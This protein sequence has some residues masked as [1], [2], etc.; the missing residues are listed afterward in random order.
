[1]S[2]A[3]PGAPFATGVRVDGRVREMLGRLRLA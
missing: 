1:V 3:V 2:S